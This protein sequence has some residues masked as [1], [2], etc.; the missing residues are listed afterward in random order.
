MRLVLFLLVFLGAVL[1]FGPVLTAVVFAGILK[2]MAPVL[3]IAA[4]VFVVVAVA[5]ISGHVSHN[6]RAA[7]ARAKIL[8]W[9]HAEGFETTEDYYAAGGALIPER[10]L[11][12]ARAR[13]F[14]DWAEFAAA[15]QAA[16]RD[17]VSVRELIARPPRK[18]LR[19]SN[20]LADE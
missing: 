1:I 9:A 14:A 4:V 20:I 19:G 12:K 2:A 6:A 7:E 10:R 11:E 17:G 13:N 8:G 16:R 18:P 5:A 3:V 15:F